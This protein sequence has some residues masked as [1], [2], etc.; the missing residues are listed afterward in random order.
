MA[1]M[2]ARE[3][4]LSIRRLDHGLVFALTGEG[5]APHE[6]GIRILRKMGGS[7]V[8]ACVV[9]CPRKEQKLRIGNT[10]NLRID[11]SVPVAGRLVA[12][13][14]WVSIPLRTT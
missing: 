4:R 8:A 9:K 5:A 7:R 14:F 1:T 3:A 13:N 2:P 11:H 12:R 10:T 6:V